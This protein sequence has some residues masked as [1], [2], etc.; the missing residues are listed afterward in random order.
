MS[1][2]IKLSPKHGLNA[3]IPICFWCGKEKNEIALMGHVKKK[4]TRPNAYGGTSTRIV[5]DDVEMPMHTCLDTIPCEEC[6]QKWAL[7]VPLIRASAMKDDKRTEVTA[8]DGSKVYLDGRYSVITTEAF[9]RIFKQ[10]RGKGQPV[11]LEDKVY[12]DLFRDVP[13]TDVTKEN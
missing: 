8:A 1:K 12:D 10:E 2:S 13:E 4:E 3:T 7:G 9:Q 11:Y 6:A 5:D